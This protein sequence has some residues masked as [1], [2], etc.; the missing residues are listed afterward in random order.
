MYNLMEFETL[1]IYITVYKNSNVRVCFLMDVLHA[2]EL[3]ERI[4]LIARLSST[5]E[6]HHNDREIA[7]IWIAEMADQAMETL[8]SAG[9]GSMKKEDVLH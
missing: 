5:V 6:C 7:V 3:L 9:D 1:K 8:S 2:A 4:A